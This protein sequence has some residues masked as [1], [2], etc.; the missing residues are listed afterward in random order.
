MRRRVCSTVDGESP[1]SSND[2]GS[3]GMT[4]GDSKLFLVDSISVP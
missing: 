3:R 2:S 4:I 1:V